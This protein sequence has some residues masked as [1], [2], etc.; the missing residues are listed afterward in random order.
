L[1]IQVGRGLTRLYRLLRH[2]RIE[3]QRLTAPR[4][5]LL[6]SERARLVLALDGAAWH[7]GL[8]RLV[9]APAAAPLCLAPHWPSSPIKVISD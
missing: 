5:R 8:R 6:G 3:D 4:L 7:H 1:G 9:A 2:A